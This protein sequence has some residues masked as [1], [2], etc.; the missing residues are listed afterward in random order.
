M[1]LAENSRFITSRA[2]KRSHRHGLVKIGVNP[3]RYAIWGDSQRLTLP[4]E[5][6]PWPNIP[7]L[8]TTNFRGTLAARCLRNKLKRS[9]RTSQLAMPAK[10]RSTT[11]ATFRTLCFVNS[12]QVRNPSHML[13]NRSAH[14]H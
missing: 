13:V 2:V 5:N 1:R 11:S 7:A 3:F 9:R 14:V 10:K 6:M 12:A 4:P 8:P